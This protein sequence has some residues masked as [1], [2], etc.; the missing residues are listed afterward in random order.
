[1]WFAEFLVVGF[2]SV[3][4]VKPTQ[5]YFSLRWEWPD[6][7]TY[8]AFE[9]GHHHARWGAIAREA[10]KLASNGGGTVNSIVFRTPDLKPIPGP[11]W[12]MARELIDDAQ[13]HGL[14]IVPLTIDEVC[15]LHA[16]REFYSNALQGNVDFQPTEVLRFLRERFTPW[17]KKYSQLHRPASPK[18]SA[19][20]PKVPRVGPPRG[21]G[22]ACAL[23]PAQVNTVVSY[24]QE[25]KLAAIE[26]VLDNLGVGDS[27]DA[28]LKAVENHPNLKAHPGPRTIVLQ[29]RNV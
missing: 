17:F 21:N 29:W 24:L 3:N 13:V 6:R 23:T 26:E 25:R 14:Y 2:D 10:T 7:S 8:F 16:A 15:N 1:M 22:H 4:V 28:L 5:R 18:K 12:T 20:K 19:A 11:N 27:K 9:A